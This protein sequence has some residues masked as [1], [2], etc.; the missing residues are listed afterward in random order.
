MILQCILK[1]INIFST[2]LNVFG[3]IY[4]VFQCIWKEVNVLWE[5]YKYMECISMYINVF[6]VFY[7]GRQECVHREEKTLIGQLES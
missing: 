6:S 2:Y 3:W 5:Y 4:N 7:V 1:D